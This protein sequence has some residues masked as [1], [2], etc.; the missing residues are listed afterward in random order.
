MRYSVL[1]LALAAFLLLV[2]PGQARLGAAPDLARLGAAPEV[3]AGAGAADVF[4]NV[5]ATDARDVVGY[6]N[7]PVLTSNRTHIIFWEPQHSHLAFD[8]GYRPL[9]RRFLRDVAQ[10]S[11]RADNVFA[12]TGQYTDSSGR[13]AAYASQFGGSV[14]DTHRLPQNG[15]TEP[16]YPQGPGWTVC[17]TESQLQG[18][19][20]H[21]VRA[22][23]LPTTQR[24]VYFLVTPK[25]LGSC[26]ES[27]PTSG[28]SLGGKDNGYCGYH[29]HTNDALVDFAIIPYT[30]VVGHCESNVPRP[31]G[32]TADP[33][34]SI[35]S[36]ELAEM[37]TDPD[38]DGW[39]DSSGDEIA[40]LCITH[41]GPA[42]GGAGQRAY[43][44][45]IAGGHFFL[46]ELWSNAANR[47]EPQAKPDHASFVVSGRSGRTLTFRAKGS[48][49]QG[50]IVSYHWLF[51]DGHRATGRTVTHRFTGR[52]TYA[53]RLRATDSWANWVSYARTVSVA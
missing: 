9:V 25:G 36:H 22:H 24:D 7:G 47:C 32:N 51:G 44:E 23:Q 28:C 27:L 18:E 15:C 34:L 53:V 1:G 31:N 40:D 41:F 2:A 49:P 26:Y 10:A 16:P 37:I 50:R 39:T 5:L 11:H 6:G 3:G 30:A 35:V 48:D 20:E 8:P 19:I 13:P 33:S 12:L 42:I 21:V 14:L 46:Q 43:N 38:G 29:D 4:H 52:G 45:N 17:L